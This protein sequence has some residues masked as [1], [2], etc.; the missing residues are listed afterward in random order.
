MANTYKVLAANILTTTASTITFTGIDQ[1]FSDLCLI[2]NAQTDN[3]STSDSALISFNS[4]TSSYY[5]IGIQ[6]EASLTW[7]TGVSRVWLLGS[8]N[9]NASQ[10][11][12]GEL[13]IS[14]YSS[15]TLNK[16]AGLQT[17]AN[18]VVS[19]SLRNFAGA[20]NNSN[21]I[22]DITLTPLSGT[23]FNTGS[24]FYLYALADS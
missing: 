16:R 20:W 7:P 23:V 24:S 17:A 14:R 2:F 6:S 22:T 5:R 19:P 13:W 11:G 18:G 8:G 9:T 21:A 12:G 3:A 10:F 1:T 15:S 4:N